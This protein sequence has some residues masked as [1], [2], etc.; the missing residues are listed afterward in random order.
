MVMMGGRRELS[1]D[2]RTRKGLGE[3]MAGQQKVGGGGK[4][5]SSG[6]TGEDMANER[7]SKKKEQ[8]KETDRQTN[9]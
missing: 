2:G 3:V 1:G 8:Q 9:N 5:R 7:K 6:R 4:D